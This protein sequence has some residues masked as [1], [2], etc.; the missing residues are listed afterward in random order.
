MPQH[1]DSDFVDYLLELL[2]PFG[3]VVAKRMFGGHGIFKDSLM[4]ALIADGVVFLKVDEVN[5]P[6]FDALDLPPF[7][8]EM[9]GGKTGTMSYYQCPEDALENG[10]TMIRWA[11]SAYSAAVRNAKS[12]KQR[13]T[14]KKKS[15]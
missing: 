13:S 4:F 5:Q 9:K 15:S 3:S 8:F 1:P 7:Q 14:K 12:K 10:A 6:E 11:E 2:E